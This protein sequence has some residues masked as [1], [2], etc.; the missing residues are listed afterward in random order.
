MSGLNGTHDP[1]LKSWVKSANEAGAEFPIQN[2]PLGVFRA[3]GPEEYMRGGVAIGD[4]IL[5]IGACLEKGF[6]EGDAKEAA[7]ACT[8][9]SLNPLMAL[10]G[11]FW[12]A[13]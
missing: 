7:Q 13:R 11:K 1:A 2:L 10:G 8:G 4:Q 12:S 5:D 6:F 9:P 3:N